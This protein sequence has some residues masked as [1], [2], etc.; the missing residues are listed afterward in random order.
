[1]HAVANI[2]VLLQAFTA[3]PGDAG[4]VAGADRLRTARELRLS[5]EP[6]RAIQELTKL[7]NTVGENAL[8]GPLH[9]H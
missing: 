3:L 4:S 6:D 1:M 2:F 8:S 7:L 9:K 5:G